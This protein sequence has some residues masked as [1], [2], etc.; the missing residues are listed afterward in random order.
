MLPMVSIVVIGGGT[1]SYTVLRGL[2]R[3]TSEIT[4]VVSM[5]D[6]GGSTGVLRDE[7]GILPPGDVRR[8][9]LALS[10]EEAQTKVLR[11]LFNMR[12]ESQGSLGGHS[13]GNLL[14]TALTKISK[15]EAEAIQKAAQLLQIRGQVLPVTL[16]NRTLCAEL[17]DG[18][19]VKGETNIDIP[20]H[21]H[22]L[23][24]N[25]IFLD[26][27]A[28]AYPAVLN[29]IREA[30]LIVLGPGDLYTSVLP[31][32]L[33]DGVSKAVA[34]SDA[35]KVYVCNLMTKPG[36]TTGFAASDFLS[37]VTRYLGGRPV[38]FIVCNDKLGS[39]DLLARYARQLA[40]PV[41]IDKDA[42]DAMG[43]RLISSDLITEPD[44][45]RHDPGKL[46][47]LIISLV[48]S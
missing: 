17:P 35:V 42:I 15:D 1:G 26:K 33:V 25:R 30:D 28:V 19:V 18:S 45:I 5:F 7:F 36:E 9:L 8:C 14:L 31:N 39:H 38:D 24:I 40:F 20:K 2:K 13:F 23:R 11:E 41:A 46:A 43:V 32:L 37:E 44:L 12:F 34:E 10:P 29:A 3:H 6:S 4:A 16:D 47:G 21:D 22:S 27:P 48:K